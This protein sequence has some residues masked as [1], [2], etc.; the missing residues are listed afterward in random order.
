MRAAVGDTVRAL[1]EIVRTDEH[2]VTLEFFSRRH[3]I[4]CDRLDGEELIRDQ[5]SSRRG[6][7]DCLN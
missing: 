3:T 5:L 6:F 7:H 1:L 4:P 2:K